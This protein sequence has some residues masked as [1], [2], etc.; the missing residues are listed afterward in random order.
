MRKMAQPI[1]IGSMLVGVVAIGSAFAFKALALLSWLVAVLAIMAASVILLRNPTGRFVRNQFSTGVRW[2]K[3]S[4]CP[5][6]ESN[7]RP[8]FRRPVLYPLSYGDFIRNNTM[9]VN[10]SQGK[11]ER[12]DP[13]ATTS[14]VWYSTPE[15]HCLNSSVVR[16]SRDKRE[17]N[18]SQKIF[19]VR[20]RVRP[21][22]PSLQLII[23]RPDYSLF[24]VV[25]RLLQPQ[26]G[27]SFRNDFHR[28][29]I[30]FARIR[31]IDAKELN[32]LSIASPCSPSSRHI[33]RIKFQ[34]RLVFG[35]PCR[36]ALNAHKPGLL[37]CKEANSPARR[38]IVGQIIPEMISKRLQ[39]FIPSFYEFLCNS[40]MCS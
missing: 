32:I 31:T 18:T 27:P 3:D 38:Y 35:H 40:Q 13:A 12:F 39:D 17:S 30:D 23:L 4:K 28:N 20:L 37:M 1:I 33:V 22:P 26:N 19:V 6:Q 2:A 36:F 5:R 8:W 34:I 9:L 21:P 7:L 29:K 24:L 15:L 25:F 14:R 16:L 11:V 10:C